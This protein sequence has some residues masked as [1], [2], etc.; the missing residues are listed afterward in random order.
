MVTQN[1]DKYVFR[2]LVPSLYLGHYKY[3]RINGGSK[4]R[5]NPWSSIAFNTDG[6]FYQDKNEN[7]QIKQVQNGVQY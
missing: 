3:M 7:W 6:F 4:F 2:L 1:S 5:N